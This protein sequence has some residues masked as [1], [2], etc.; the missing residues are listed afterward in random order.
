MGIYFK[1]GKNNSCHQF[2]PAQ[3]FLFCATTAKQRSEFGSTFPA[4]P[5]LKPAK[6]PSSPI[7]TS[8]FH[9]QVQRQELQKDP[10]G[11]AA[12]VAVR[13]PSEGERQ[14]LFEPTELKISFL[15]LLATLET[16]S[17][18]LNLAPVP[19]AFPALLSSCGPCCYP[20]PAC[21]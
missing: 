14:H 16:S 12:G 10:S 5:L 2:F 15:P 6:F 21:T 4:Q 1:T 3:A 19:A 8:L 17:L 9:S 18:H 13:F 20:R 7:N 11:F